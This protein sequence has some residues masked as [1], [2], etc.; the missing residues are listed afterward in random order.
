[1]DAYVLYTRLRLYYLSRKLRFD[2]DETGHK[3]S[4]Q[5]VIGEL[6]VNGNGFWKYMNQR[7]VPANE[8]NRIDRGYSWPGVILKLPLVFGLATVT[9]EDAVDK[10]EEFMVMLDQIQTIGDYL[11]SYHQT[12]VLQHWAGNDLRYRN[13]PP[14]PVDPFGRSGGFGILPNMGDTS[15]YIGQPGVS[16]DSEDPDDAVDAACTN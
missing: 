3:K 10:Y 13:L 5:Q 1:M 14:M 11:T 7:G 8:S 16:N 4:N 2:R 6:V 15:H 9:V 12:M